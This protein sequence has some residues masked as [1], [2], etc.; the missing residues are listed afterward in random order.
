M[1]R[2]LELGLNR[3]FRSRWGIALILLILV[4]AIVG[5][6][7]LF[8]GANSEQP[9]V[10]TGS[11]APAISVDPDDDDSV[12]SA[13]PPPLPST[14]PGG[15]QPEAVA[16]AFASAW[17]DHKNV[18]VKAWHDGIMPNATKRLADQLDN[19]DPA[20][21]PGPARPR[22]PSTWTEPDVA[23]RPASYAIYRPETGNTSR[24]PSQPRVRTEAK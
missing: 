23:E 6:G 21:V 8:H 9:L 20:D 17:S 2:T 19:V 1:P 4:L 3:I 22:R 13:A 11:P 10:S 7:R 5:V 16:Y 12:I 24:E 15:A 18:S 14:S